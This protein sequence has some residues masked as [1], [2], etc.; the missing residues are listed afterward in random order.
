MYMKENRRQTAGEDMAEKV[1]RAIRNMSKYKRDNRQCGGVR[2]FVGEDVLPA[3]LAGGLV[4]EP[5][6]KYS[7]D[8]Y[9]V[10]IMKGYPAGYISAE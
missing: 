4:R 9:P 2:V 8:G 3:L 10:L 5:C 6:G 7:L 1:R